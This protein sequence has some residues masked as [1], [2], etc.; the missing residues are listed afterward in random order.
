MPNVPA[1]IGIANEVGRKSAIWAS[2]KANAVRETHAQIAP[3][4]P[5]D[6][7]IVGEMAAV[8]APAD[9]RAALALVATAAELVLVEESWEIIRG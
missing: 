3:E 7:I 5:S 9:L 1:C 4:A 6:G 2:G 8:C